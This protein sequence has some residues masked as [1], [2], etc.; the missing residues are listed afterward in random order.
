VPPEPWPSRQIAHVWSGI[1]AKGL[2][3]KAGVAQP[4]FIP[5]PCEGLAVRFCRPIVSRLTSALAKPALARVPVLRN[6]QTRL[7]QAF[8][9]VLDEFWIPPL[10]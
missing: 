8:D 2:R 3:C 10:S 5:S 6:L 4:L 9:Q 7:A 1:V